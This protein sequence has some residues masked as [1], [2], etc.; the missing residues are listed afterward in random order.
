[1][2]AVELGAFFALRRGRHA[3]VLGSPTS[4]GIRPL[5]SLTIDG[6]WRGRLSETRWFDLL[7]M[8]IPL[9]GLFVVLA[10]SSADAVTRSFLIC[11]A[12]YSDLLIALLWSTENDDV[13]AEPPQLHPHPKQIALCVKGRQNGRP[14]FLRPVDMRETHSQRRRRLRLF[15]LIKADWRGELASR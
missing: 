6:S 4:P 5:D 14:Q 10:G 12:I 11:F 2:G 7:A 13:R 15:E 3:S 1:M 9:L 8:V